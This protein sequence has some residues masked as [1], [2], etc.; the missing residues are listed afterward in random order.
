VSIKTGF[1]RGVATV[2]WKASPAADVIADS[3]V[4]LLMHAQTSA[5]SIRLSS[6]PCR[7]PSDIEAL[8]DDGIVTSP[9]KKQRDDTNTNVSVSDVVESRLRY[10]HGILK[11]QFKTVEAVYD[12]NVGSFEI[13]TDSG[14]ETIIQ[15]NDDGKVTCAITVTVDPVSASN[16]EIRIE[17]ADEKFATS[18]RKML[19][20]AL[21]VFDKI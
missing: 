16:A 11:E 21:A 19:K 6:K 20:D 3:V 13:L 4:A 1:Q 2:E 7:H 15:S 9:T 14:L 17:C 5:A 10:V 8:D 18:I 12:S